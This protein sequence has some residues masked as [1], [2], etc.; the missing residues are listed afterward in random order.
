MEGYAKLWS[1]II[2]STIWCESDHV[3]VLW[4]TLLALA[5]AEGYVGASIPGLA[6]AAKIPLKSCESGLKKLEAPDQY[7]RTKD[8]EGRRIESVDGGWLILNYSKHRNE[9]DSVERKRQGRIR[10]KNFRDRL[11]GGWKSEI[12]KQGG[13]CDCCDQKFQ[14][15]YSKYVCRDHNHENGENRGLVCQS[16]NA[17][18]GKFELGKCMGHPPEFV[19]RYLSKWGGNVKHNGVTTEITKSND[20]AEAEA[21][22]SDKP[23][24]N[25]I[26]SAAI[27]FSEKER[28][29][30]S[31]EE[32]E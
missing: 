27:K 6:S 32:G 19:F 18:I 29:E 5:D 12:E 11:K 15:P 9:H 3:R 23:D 16:C 24:W 26:P 2:H 7:S 21:F 30:D 1:S 28:I 4:I 14:V 10:A 13:R 17:I 25:G 8:H 31:A 20:I 22:D